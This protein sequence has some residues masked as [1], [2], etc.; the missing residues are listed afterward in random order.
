[1]TG[2]EEGEKAIKLVSIG[3]QTFAHLQHKHDASTDLPSA[4]M[5]ASISPI[6]NCFLIV[7]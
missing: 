1:V 3:S 4:R 2:D 6:I 5:S 7:A